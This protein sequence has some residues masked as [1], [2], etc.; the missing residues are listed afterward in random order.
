MSL[1]EK[2]ANPENIILSSEI[3]DKKEKKRAYNREYRSRPDVKERIKEQREKNQTSKKY[4]ELVKEDPE[5]QEKRKEYIKD[6]YH[7]VLKSDPE[8][9]KKHLGTSIKYQK[10][11]VEKLSEKRKE[12]MK[13]D[14]EFAERQREVRRKAAQKMKE[15]RKMLKEM[16]ENKES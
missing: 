6:Y 13:N 14:P 5:Y 1:D 15:K 3:D 4:Y 9:Y 7:N 16:E 12:R 11:H 2:D 8:R 10:E